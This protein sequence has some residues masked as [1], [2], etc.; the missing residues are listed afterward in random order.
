MAAGELSVRCNLEG[1]HSRQFI[2]AVHDLLIF[3]YIT[4]YFYYVTKEGEFVDGH[5][6]SKSL[7]SFGRSSININFCK[8]CDYFFRTRDISKVLL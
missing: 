3:Y 1:A 4:L 7:D 6:D 2:K 5:R 8:F